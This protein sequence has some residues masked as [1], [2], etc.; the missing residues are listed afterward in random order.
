M[1][2]G[3]IDSSYMPPY[4]RDRGF[5]HSEKSVSFLATYTDYEKET[6]FRKKKILFG[7]LGSYKEP[8]GYNLVPVTREA[9]IRFDLQA[10]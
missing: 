5:E 1:G 10:K 9:D 3:D 4:A 8:N 7:L 2:K 6:K